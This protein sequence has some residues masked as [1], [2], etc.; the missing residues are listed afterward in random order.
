MLAGVALALGLAQP[1]KSDPPPSAHRV[2]SFATDP[3]WEGLNNRK[4]RRC[5]GRR[6]NFGWVAPSKVAAGGAVGGRLERATDYRAYY[7]QVLPAA[8]TLDDALSASGDLTITGTRAGFL[9]GWFNSVSSVDWRTPDFVGLRIDGIRKYGIAYG[10]YGTANTFTGTTDGTSIPQNTRVPWSL[11]YQ[12]DGGTSG[13]GLLQLT[14]GG[15][16]TETSISPLQRADGATFDRF[17][18]L[19]HQV[20]GSQ[21]SAYVGN[22]TIDGVRVDLS[23]DPGWEGLDNTLSVTDCVTHN[24]HDFGYSPGTSFAG[25]ERGEIGG[26][27]WRSS[28][29]RAWYADRIA[30]VGLDDELYAE[31]SLDVESVS[32]DADVLIGWF[33]RA[34]ATASGFPTSIVAADLGGPSDWGLRL[35]P[36]YEAAGLVSGSFEPLSKFD[37]FADAPLVSPKHHPWQWWICYRPL[38]DGRGRLT[39]GIADPLGVLPDTQVSIKVKGSAREAGPVF[40]RFGIKNLAESGHSIVFYLDDLRYTAGPGDSGPD[41]RCPTS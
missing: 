4:G 3:L 30:N 17:G 32:V 38:D 36:V 1:A 13:T 40:D 14:I 24:N 27:V 23:H 6:F 21:M 29:K 2:A 25:G 26:L 7:A 9:F 35:Y 15:I 28:T 10:E 34:S 31:G 20:D 11:T 39:V 5:T 22:L 33:N 19:N 12:P 16:T 37:R 8:K 41:E 18:L